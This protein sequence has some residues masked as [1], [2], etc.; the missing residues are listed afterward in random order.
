MLRRWLDTLIIIWEYDW[1][2]RA[3]LSFKMVLGNDSTFRVSGWIHRGHF[4]GDDGFNGADPIHR[5]PRDTEREMDDELGCP[6]GS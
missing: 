4:L 5:D 3:K 1:I 6:V 2:P